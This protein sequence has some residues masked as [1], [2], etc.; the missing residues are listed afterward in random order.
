MTQGILGTVGYYKYTTQPIK[1]INQYYYGAVVGTVGSSMAV[2]G[3]SWL[4][5]SLSYQHH[6]SKE[7]KLPTS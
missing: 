4:L 6:L 1:Q 2:V 7:K 5:S 3:N